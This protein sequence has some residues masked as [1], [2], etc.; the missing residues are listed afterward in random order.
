MLAKEFFTASG[1]RL[2]RHAQ[3]FGDINWLF[4]PGGPGIGS[5][6]LIELVDTLDMP[7]NMWLV[8]LPGD[9]SNVAPPTS[10][11][12]HYQKWPG[13]LLEAAQVVPNS[14]YVGHSTGGMYL[15]SVPELEKHIKGLVLISSAPDASWHSSFIQMTLQNPL[16]QVEKAA[17]EFEKNRT[18]E[19]LRD[20]AVA[21][22]EWNF[23]AESVDMGRQFLARMPYNFQAADWSDHCFD[24]TYVAKWWPNLLPTLILS[25]SDDRII[26]QSLWDNP[27]FQRQNVLRRTIDSAAHFLW[28]EKPEAVREAFAELTILM[29]VGDSPSPL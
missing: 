26:A 20:I 25:G 12:D 27:K 16:P 21:S 18:N 2:R 3:R 14:V 6:S 7:G 10:P 17:R 24:N 4:L 15:L 29:E 5:E 28:L 23:T 8:D 19:K 9:G 11:G 22:A 1:V 13:V